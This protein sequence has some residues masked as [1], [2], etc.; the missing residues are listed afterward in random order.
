MHFV[1]S[2]VLLPCP[3]LMCQKAGLSERAPSLA[4]GPVLLR[5]TVGV[6]LLPPVL[7]WPRLSSPLARLCVIH[8]CSFFKLPSRR[9]KFV[10]QLRG[11][12]GQDTDDQDHGWKRTTVLKVFQ[13]EEG[14]AAWPAAHLSQLAP[15]E[16]LQ[17]AIVVGKVR[18][19]LAVLQQPT[20]GCREPFLR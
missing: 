7:L 11:R 15:L 12:H 16:L 6:A 19:V 8:Q 14:M 17:Q 3:G 1:S 10:L 4:S 20:L 2:A 18:L 13:V 9:V 5:V